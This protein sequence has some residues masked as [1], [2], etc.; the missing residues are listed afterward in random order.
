M[1]QSLL[2][3]CS[4]NVLRPSEC[5]YVGY[6]NLHKFCICAT[7]AKRVSFDPSWLKFRK[8]NISEKF[9][10][11]FIN[12]FIHVISY[13]KYT[14][15]LLTHPQET[16]ASQNNHS[17]LLNPKDCAWFGYENTTHRTS[18]SN[19]SFGQ[20]VEMQTTNKTNKKPQTKHTQLQQKALWSCWWTEFV[21]I[22]FLQPLKMKEV[23][24]YTILQVQRVMSNVDHLPFCLNWFW[25]HSELETGR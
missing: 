8:F 11:I 17:W 20:N 21:I 1:K 7:V 2:E 5:H 10:K 23:T 4:A 14:L 6:I 12:V 3:I 25:N 16:T 15:F 9:K 13:R 22:S 18:S 24:D 19:I